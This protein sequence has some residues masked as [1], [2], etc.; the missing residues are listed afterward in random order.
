MDNGI[1]FVGLSEYEN[2]DNFIGRDNFGSIGAV[3]GSSKDSYV[4]PVMLFYN[5]DHWHVVD[6][7]PQSK[8][9]HGTNSPYLLTIGINISAEIKTYHQVTNVVRVLT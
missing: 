8:I 7:Y 9:C 1:D 2:K 4:S 3:C 5:K 6:S